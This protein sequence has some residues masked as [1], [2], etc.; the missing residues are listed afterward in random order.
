MPPPSIVTS[1]LSVKPLEPVLVFN[2]NE[3]AAYFQS[4]CRQ[5]RILADQRLRWVFLPM[6]EGL[7]RVRTAHNGDVSYDFSTHHHAREFNESISNLGRIYQNTH[8]KPIRDR[9]VYLGRQLR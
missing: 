3:D 7:L 6:P 2:T 8:D 4:H 9:S 5:G 1:F